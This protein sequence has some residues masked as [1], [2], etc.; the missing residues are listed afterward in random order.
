MTENQDETYHGYST[1]AE[2]QPQGD[3]DSMTSD[4]GLAEPL[5]E[6]YS[7]PEQWSAGQG[8]G[9]T[10]LEEELGESIDQRLKQEEPEPD[11][12]AAAAA[13]ADDLDRVLDDGEVG[14]D[15]SGRLVSPDEGL[16]EDVDAEMLA[17]DV[18]IDGAGASAEEAAM[19]E[20]D[21]P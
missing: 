5:D 19:H 9:N 4:R 2:D 11:P 3:G 13:E 17:T 12:Y 6:G 7:P 16:T 20:V 15:R 18:G 10:P 1:D 21:Q 8:Y 14:D